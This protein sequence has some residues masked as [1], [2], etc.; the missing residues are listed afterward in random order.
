MGQEVSGRVLHQLVEQNLLEN[1]DKEAIIFNGQKI[2][3]GQLKQKSDYLSLYILESAADQDVIGLSTT[4]S[5]EM[6]VS[7]LAILKAG[8][9]YLPL[10]PLL[11][12]SRL[13]D[14]MD[15]SRVR[16]CLAPESEKDFFNG[17]G[18]MTLDQGKSEQRLP[19]EVPFQNKNACILYTSG[20]TGKPKGVC[21]P[22]AGLVNFIIN[23]PNT[24]KNPGIIATQ[25]C[26]LG[27]DVSIDEIF[28]PLAT[29]GTLHIL[30]DE[31]RLDSH[32]L[33]SYIDRHGIQRIY[34]PYVELQYFAEEAVR[35]G[36]FPGSLSEVMSMGEVLKISPA[37]RELFKNL[38]RCRLI[39]KYGPTEA[40]VYVTDNL[41]SNN[42]DEWEEVP[43][44]GKPISGVA[45]H[46]LDERL[47]EVSLGELGEL[48]IS[49]I[50]V[51]NGY[52][53]NPELTDAVFVN[54]MDGKG[55]TRKIYRTGDI[56]KYLPDGSIA[57]EGRRDGQVK[58]RGNRVEISEIEIALMKIAS[59]HQAT[60]IAREDVPG[61]KYLAAY[62]VSREVQID[63]QVIRQKLVNTLPDYMVPSH[64]I[65]ME[66]LPKTSSGKV[67]RKLLP[68]PTNTRPEL[69]TLFKKPG[70]ELETFLAESV[71]QVLLFDRIG[72][73]DNFFELG[74]NSLL[75][76]KLITIF[77]THTGKRLPITRLYQTP[78]VS[79]MAAFFEKKPETRGATRK[80]KNKNKGG[81]DAIAI[82]GMAGRFPGAYSI[83]EIWKILSEGKETITFFNE[84]ELDKS[85][86]E[87]LRK[88]P[89]YVRARG[90][91]EGVEDFDPDFFG[92]NRKLATLMDP[93]QRVFLEV[94]W[95]ALEDAG[96]FPQN[97]YQDI[98]VFAGCYFNNYY[99]NNVLQNPE[100]IQ[101][102]GS[103]QV[104]TAN[105]KDYISSRTA[106]HL[107]LKGPAISVYSACSTSLLAI[108]QAIDAIRSG[109]CSMA[110]AGAAS[111]SA[112]YKVGHLYEEGSMLSADGHCKPFQK[113]STGTMFNDGAG[114]VLLK[115]LEDAVED[116][117]YVYAVVRGV[118]VNNDG[119]SKGS[120]TAPSSEGQA[121]A[122]KMAIED[123]E[124]DASEIQYVEAHGTGTPIGDPIEIEGLKMA[125][126]G[127][128]IKQ[129]CGIGSI[130][131]N[132]GHLTA[133]AGV[134]GTIKVALALTNKTLPPSLGFEVS[135]PSIDF[136]D[137]PFFVVDSLR[138]WKADRKRIAG[139]SSFGVG[140]T[141]VHIIMEGYENP[142]RPKQSHRKPQL[143]CWSAKSPES[144]EKYRSRISEY[145]KSHPNT[146]LQNIAATLHAK[147]ADFN[148]KS[149]VVA[150]S[151]P[152]LIG[153]L[154]NNNE[155][156]LQGSNDLKNVPGELVFTFPG[157]GSQFLNMGSG[158]YAS[159]SVFQEAVDRC[160]VILLPVLGEDI[161]Q[162]LYPQ[163]L[164]REAEDKINNT[165]FTQPAIFVVSYALAQ[166]W[167]SWGIKPAVLCGHSIGEFVAAHLAEVFS[168]EDALHIVSIRGKMV[169][170]LPKGSMLSI[171]MEKNDLIPLIPQNLSL[172]A[173]N[174]QNS[175]VVSGED[176]AI[177]E[178]ARK[179]DSME[180][181]NKVLATSHAFHSHMMD[182]IMDTFLEML[183]KINLSKPSIP[184]VSTVTGDWLKD[185]EAEDPAY[186]AKHLRKTVDFSGALNTVSTLDMPIILEV[187]P[188]MVTASL[189]RQQIGRKAAS[190]LNSLDKT[191]DSDEQRNLLSVLGELWTRGISPDWRSFYGGEIPET[192]NI[193]HYAFNKK[194]CWVDP[195]EPINRMAEKALESASSDQPK[196]TTSSVESSPSPSSE[197]LAKNK[198]LHILEKASGIPA[199]E[200]QNNLTF[201]Q[202]GFDSL[203]LTQLAFNVKK[204]LEVPVTFRQLN[205][206]LATPDLLFEYVLATCIVGKES[207]H[208]PDKQ[209]VIEKKMVD[210]HNPPCTNAKLGRDR[211][212]N[213]AWFIQDE[214]NPGKYLQLN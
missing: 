10:D 29:G 98:G 21:V 130:K 95:E 48:C 194:R 30:D 110:L 23:D 108:V 79:G 172:A 160:S 132:I 137:S 2:T 76:Q 134:A 57:F 174:S 213:P 49:G 155:Y 24:Y 64:F 51:A 184:I 149:Y 34:L 123:A 152:E 31:R 210:F 20:S 207:V 77:F 183:K 33:L 52:L 209:Q 131:S 45:I 56:G 62:L 85:V 40:C 191:A 171:K 113:G 212:G 122:I 177:A 205:S 141:N 121:A 136:K 119:G 44:I 50:A 112:P 66:E 168:L 169:S 99:I 154:Q 55:N 88:D 166:L 126:G 101:Q 193:P 164:D 28:V 100:L 25:F 117:D 61:K 148:H 105:D 208:P 13:Q 60:V 159:E 65:Q 75:A 71:K 202:Q 179:L 163:V 37:I 189:A 114:V 143:I 197:N 120:F 151:L 90:I 144:R 118:G 173:I 70:T 129:Y 5:I 158:L 73:D 133:A 32:N 139:V 145:V 47:N 201:S 190:I 46:F 175:C 59:I 86:P 165:Q 116:G 53:N 97:G 188:G 68:Q 14:I 124:I 4:R 125:F 167:I 35:T 38:P 214:K 93:Q 87:Q 200:I 178:L 153:A 15:N 176:D 150:E 92:I 7:L 185:S 104:L 146:S 115:R 192:C 196:L 186:W 170:E 181:P 111:I 157:Q 74:G 84:E 43:S 211:N 135:N 17:L 82:I 1:F 156:K 42:P 199:N 6:V 107:D 147:R 180:V 78:S 182:P 39:N 36:F 83:D 41:L 54:W 195:V 109:K 127:Q 102:L 140:G 94:A 142:P 8:K 203:L 161:R 128:S 3:Y 69:K 11:P 26:H 63:V 89:L 12:S 206:E 81:G 58:I 198:L 18:L 204:E 162:V 103:F 80:R 138:P 16:F 67:D 19:I 106:Y 91:I 96:Y 22:H 72:I 187:G 9:A 27:F